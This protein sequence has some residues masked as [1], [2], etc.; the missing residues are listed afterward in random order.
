VVY[1][2]ALHF[3]ISIADVINNAGT[4]KK[5]PNKIVIYLCCMIGHHGQKAVAK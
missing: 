4:L 2:M 3:N 5:F 1:A